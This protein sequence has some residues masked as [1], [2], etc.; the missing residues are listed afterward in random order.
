MDKQQKKAVR[1]DS[2]I[3]KKEKHRGLKEGLKK[4]WGVKATVVPELMG[5]LG[6]VTPRNT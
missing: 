2:N 5:A 3:R 6:A 4:M 1:D